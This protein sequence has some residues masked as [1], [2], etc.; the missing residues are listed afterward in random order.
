MNAGIT[1]VCAAILLCFGLI[2]GAHA[3]TDDGAAWD[4]V[5]T[6]AET[7]LRNGQATD[8]QLSAQ[9]ERLSELREQALVVQD[10]TKDRLTSL[11]SQL[12]ALGP[13]PE[14]DETEVAD[15]A[16]MRSMLKTQISEVRT[17]M[18][19]A[20]AA[21]ARAEG[22]IDEIDAVVRE[23]L[24][25]RL[26]KLGPSPLNP[27]H[28]A[29][30]WGQITAL[31]A[32]IR[33]SAVVMRASVSGSR[34]WVETVPLAIVLVIGG[35]ALLTRVRRHLTGLVAGRL[36]AS[37]SP[38][39]RAALFFGLN[40]VRLIIPAMA[41]VLFVVALDQITPD[42]LA[43]E[44]LL[45]GF[46]LLVIAMIAAQWLAYSLFSPAELNLAILKRDLRHAREGWRMTLLLGFVAGGLGAVMVLYDSKLINDEA[47]AI[48]SLPLQ[49]LGSFGLYRLA[50]IVRM[51]PEIAEGSSGTS[52]VNL[53]LARLMF[54]LAVVIPALALVG[55]QNLAGFLLRPTIYSLAL[56]GAMLVIF[57]LFRDSLEQW[58]DASGDENRRSAR[59]RFRLLPVLIGF[60]LICVALPVLTLIW[61][62]RTAD[63]QDVWLWLRNGIQIG[64]ARLSVTDF[65]A[66]VLIFVIGYTITRM[67]QAVIRNT[68]LPR[69]DIDVG[70]RNAI[71][72]GV[73]YTGIFLA[74]VAAISSTGL[75]LSN[76]A[77]VAGALSVGIGFGLQTIVSN[78]VS[79]I[80]L[81]I[82]RP[83]KEGDWIEVAGYSGYVKGISVRSTEIETFDRASVIVPNSELIAGSVLNWTH[84][85]M[86]GRVIV[87][88]GVAYG[89]D[90][91]QVEK[92]L[93]DIAEAHPM[94]LRVPAPS[95]VFMGFGA[96]SMD[97]QI[98]AQ[99]RDVNFM[100][101]VKSE[102]NYEIVEKFAEAGIEIPFAQRDVNLRNVDDLAAM[103]EKLQKGAA[104]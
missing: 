19:E 24:S 69:T 76:L 72:A 84:S 75:N 71:L 79:G 104:Q 67:V 46:I 45:S 6:Q 31:G 61:G 102:M 21:Y 80:I 93:R 82:E 48:L 64:D 77:I 39:G 62:A 28:W 99:L 73:G 66:F 103:L 86:T 55:Y 50:R 12:D 33:Q 57:A 51:V 27:A 42:G 60:A 52:T 47:T 41:A 11:Q 22:L 49:V 36:A 89:T 14:G 4:R 56:V 59:A 53:N 95:V 94:V 54:A 96:D 35:I 38:S 29:E 83:I 9:R 43:T 65:M 81:L 13:A 88:V 98:R 17:P 2:A 5:T 97:F 58:L 92:I 15:I 91:R 32:K 70:G 34:L 3:Q 25:E 63:L 40:L 68:V 10:R 18:I 23:R 16:T 37:H 85:N 90:P 7:L 8:A 1:R 78:F 30:A 87:P 74:A 101:S 26:T 100:L 20:D 44:A